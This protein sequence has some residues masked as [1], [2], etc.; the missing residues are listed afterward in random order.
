TL[1]AGLNGSNVAQPLA[2][3][4]QPTIY[5]LKVTDTAGTVQSDTVAAVPGIALAIVNNPGN[6]GTVVRNIVKD[7]Y[8]AGEQITVEAVPNAGYLFDHWANPGVEFTNRPA[9]NVAFTENPTTL[10]FQSADAHVEAVFR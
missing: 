2:R 8:M 6:A 7:L 10:T 4:A 5:T 3:P 9:A 1:P